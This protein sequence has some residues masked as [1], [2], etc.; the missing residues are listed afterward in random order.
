MET[1]FLAMYKL[2]GVKEVS[3]ITTKSSWGQ[4][5]TLCTFLMPGTKAQPGK[6]TTF[7]F[8][9]LNEYMHVIMTSYLDQNVSSR[10]VE[11]LKIKD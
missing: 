1:M 9:D 6:E 11:T 10:V 8:W 4:N 7:A 2:I 5:V 3:N